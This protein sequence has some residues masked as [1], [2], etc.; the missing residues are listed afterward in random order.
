MQATALW[1]EKYKKDFQAG[2]QH[3]EGLRVQRG[4]KAEGKDNI[5]F[6]FLAAVSL[7]L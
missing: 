5:R 3:Q 7:Q 4:Q 1:E 6:P 2:Q